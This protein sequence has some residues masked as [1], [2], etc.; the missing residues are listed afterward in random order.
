MVIG[1]KCCRSLKLEFDLRINTEICDS[2][3][4]KKFYIEA[5]IDCGATDS[6]ID[7]DLVDE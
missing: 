2:S 1:R 7:Q 5:L 4:M 6:F 3:T